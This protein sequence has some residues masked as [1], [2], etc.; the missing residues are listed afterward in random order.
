MALVREPRRWI[1]WWCEGCGQLN[2]QDYID[3]DCK[4]AGCGHQTERVVVEEVLDAPRSVHTPAS[5]AF[6][7]HAQQRLRRL[8]E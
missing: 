1:R 5:L 6:L 4:C 7:E 2:D 8:E 3:I